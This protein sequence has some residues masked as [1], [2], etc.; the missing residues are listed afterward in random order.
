MWEIERY[1]FKPDRHFKKPIPA[2]ALFPLILGGLSLGYFKWLASL[3]F[4]VKAKTYRAA[5]RH[6]LYAFSEMT[7]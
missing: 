4:D 7:E 6:G 5:K 2:G 3:V 1:G